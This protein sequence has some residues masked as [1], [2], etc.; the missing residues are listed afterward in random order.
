MIVVVQLARLATRPQYVNRTAKPILVSDH[1]AT[2]HYYRL[3]LHKLNRENGS[4]YVA[5]LGECHHHPQQRRR[6]TDFC[7]ILHLTSSRKCSRPQYIP[8]FFL[9]SSL[10][11][12]IH[13]I[14]TLSISS[15]TRLTYFVSEYHKHR[16]PT[17]TGTSNRKKHS[18][19]DC[20]RRRLSRRM[21]SSCMITES[22]CIRWRAML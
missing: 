21:I 7:E 3:F 6:H 20:W 17:H 12:P 11:P 15:R 5:L 2:F 22:C 14:S 8:T 4:E 10:S 9:H 19:K 18:R 16:N 13:S 1:I